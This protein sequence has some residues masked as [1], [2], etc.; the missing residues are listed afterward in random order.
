MEGSRQGAVPS[1]KAL[2]VCCWRG[3][4]GEAQVS[5]VTAFAIC[6]GHV[7]GVVDLLE[8]WGMLSTLP[9]KMTVVYSQ[10]SVP[11]P[12]CSRGPQIQNSR[13]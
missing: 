12:L 2:W 5:D 1:S 4:F 13:L 9:R 8:K 10:S 6:S 3:R 11:P 7:L